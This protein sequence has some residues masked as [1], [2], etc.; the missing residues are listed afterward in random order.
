LVV[1]KV[2]MKEYEKVAALVDEKVVQSE[3]LTVKRLEVLMVEKMGSSM[4]STK[5]ILKVELMEK[6]MAEKTGISRG[7][8]KE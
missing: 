8:K 4:V 6:K 5:E 7:M 3:S 1:L 2:A